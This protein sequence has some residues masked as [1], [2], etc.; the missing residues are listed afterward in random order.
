MSLFS[1]IKKAL[2]VGKL[3]SAL[4]W[5]FEATYPDSLAKYSPMARIMGKD[6]QRHLFNMSATGSLFGY[7][8]DYEVS[9]ERGDSSTTAYR[10]TYQNLAKSAAILAM[11]YGGSALASAGGSEAGAGAGTAEGAGAGAEADVGGSFAASGETLTGGST[12]S[13]TGAS[14]VGAAGT[15]ASTTTGAGA[16]AAAPAAAAPAAASPWYAGVAKEAIAPVITV[17]GQMLASKNT[18]SEGENADDVI[19]ARQRRNNI[20][21]V[22]VTRRTQRPYVAPYQGNLAVMTPEQYLAAGGFTRQFNPVNPTAGL[23][24]QKR[25]GSLGNASGD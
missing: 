25:T 6:Y 1:S 5:A 11:V 4:N 18:P 17:G 19:A 20:S 22:G 10:H 23:L 21:G 24:T 2:G 7:Q 9:R 13:V 12:A 8:A 15:T 14:T 3:A 16:A